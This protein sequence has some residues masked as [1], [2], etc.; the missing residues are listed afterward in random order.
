MY[1]WVSS[2][3][4]ISPQ[5][6]LGCDGGGSRELKSNLLSP[7]ITESWMLSGTRGGCGHCHP[8]ETTSPANPSYVPVTHLMGTSP[9]SGYKTMGRMRVTRWLSPSLS[10]LWAHSPVT[11]MVAGSSATGLVVCLFGQIPGLLKLSLYCI[12]F[13]SNLLSDPYPQS[14]YS[15]RHGK[16]LSELLRFT[17]VMKRLLRKKIFLSL[18]F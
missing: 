14:L 5:C 12:F 4:T 1:L 6:E 7:S 8:C 13:L 11:A 2:H 3:S 10:D 18:F 9:F 16:I 17:L 15:I